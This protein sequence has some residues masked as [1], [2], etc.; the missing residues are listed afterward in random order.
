M[1]VEATNHNKV[2]TGRMPSQN[3]LRSSPGPTYYAKR[4]LIKGSIMSAFT[5]FIDDFMICKIVS[6][7]ETEARSRLKN[8]TW[9]TFKEIYAL[10][11][12]FFARGL[13]AK[14]QQINDLWSKVWGPSFFRQT[15]S[16]DQCKELLEFIRFDV[17]SSRIQRVQSD[18]FTLISTI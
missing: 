13:I 1:W 10:L 4:K 8:N 17:R 16:R 18:R 11:G 14:G 15:M 2:A 6:C 9:S 12:I 3:V 7:T 5:L